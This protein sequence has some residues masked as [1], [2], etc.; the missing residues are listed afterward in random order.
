MTPERF[1]L[2]ERKF[3]KRKIALARAFVERL[4]ST[5]FDDIH[6]S[7]VCSGV[8]VSPATFFNYFPRK[9]DPIYYHN[10]L[11]TIRVIWKAS[12]MAQGK[13]ALDFI[14]AAFD[15]LIAE[16]ENPNVVYEIISTL[17]GQKQSPQPMPISAAEKYYAFPG[18]EG[19]EQIQT[20][21][22][23]LEDL[24]DDCLKKAIANGELPK[25]ANI[26]DV[27]MMLRTILVGVPLAVK[28]ENFKNIGSMYKKQLALIWRALGR[29]RR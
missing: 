17:V 11:H 8:D 26:K 10:Q 4:Q 19:I 14:D 13:Q 28:F 16:Y 21:S 24:F 5:R 29:K 18:C 22:V 9:I 25:T 12:R 3:A 15:E 7:E 1:T 6:I 23:L 2:R 20:T 27:A